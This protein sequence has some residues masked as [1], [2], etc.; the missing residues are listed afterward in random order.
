MPKAESGLPTKVKIGAFTYPVE[1]VTDIVR[2]ATPYS[3]TFSMDHISRDNQKI[4]IKRLGSKPRMVET[5]VHEIFHGIAEE[6]A[7]YDI[8]GFAEQEEKIADRM[9]KGF[10]KF[11]VDNPGF[12]A[13]LEQALKT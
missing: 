3:I 1:Y 4:R 13:K 11:L 7:L 8:K 5:L 12:V 6:N 9:S 10:T 2:D